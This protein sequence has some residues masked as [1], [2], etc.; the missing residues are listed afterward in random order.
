MERCQFLGR[1]GLRAVTAVMLD[2]E[3]IASSRRCGAIQCRA[4][5]GV[6]CARLCMRRVVGK[7]KHAIALVVLGGICCGLGDTAG[8]AE[9]LG[10]NW[11]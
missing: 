5:L 1:W 4:L 9:G 7:K 10:Y 11:E 2:A 6:A 3:W 8:H